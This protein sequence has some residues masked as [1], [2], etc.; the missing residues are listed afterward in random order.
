VRSLRQARA[1]DQAQNTKAEAM[2]PVACT[3]SIRP[4][5]AGLSQKEQ[6]RLTEV[7]QTLAALHRRIMEFDAVMADPSAFLRSDSPGHLA[8]R[9]K[10]TSQFELE[11]FELEWLELEDK[12]T[13]D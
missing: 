1:A 13:R 4:K 8:L 11:I 5:K 2:R 12:R 10:E 9:A 7:E 3:G 6:R